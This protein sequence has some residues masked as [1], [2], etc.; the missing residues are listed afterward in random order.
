MKK[1][2]SSA[3]SAVWVS[4][5]VLTLLTGWQEERRVCKRTVGQLRITYPKTFTSIF[6][7]T[8]WVSQHQKGK[9]QSG[10]KWGKRW[11]V[12][13]WQ[14]FISWTICKQSA[15]RSRQVTTPTRHHSIFTGRMLFLTPSQQCQSTEGKFSTISGGIKKV[16]QANADLLAK[17]Q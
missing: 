16:E 12:L 11:G 1:G 9:N 4:F 10:F 13:R 14:W 5:S 17:R 6:S 3:Y 8:T 2:R 15:P 7:R